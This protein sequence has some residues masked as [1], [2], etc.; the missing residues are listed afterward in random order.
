[1]TVSR[2]EG[3]ICY[4]SWIGTNLNYLR[5]MHLNSHMV[6][7]TFQLLLHFIDKFDWMVHLMYIFWIPFL[8]NFFRTIHHVLLRTQYTFICLR[9]SC[10]NTFVHGIRWTILPH[11][12]ILIGSD[13]WIL[14]I[15]DVHCGKLLFKPIF[16]FV[17]FFIVTLIHHRL[18]S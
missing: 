14:P 8:F 1:M 16:I 9:L 11:P 7:P 12:V 5:C 15:F 10:L 2:S 13:C 4:A 3:F 17:S 18:S 6:H